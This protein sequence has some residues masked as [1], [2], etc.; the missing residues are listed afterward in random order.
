MLIKIEGIVS[1]IISDIIL[2]SNQFQYRD[3]D[4]FF[5]NSESRRLAIADAQFDQLRG[6]SN[7]N[8][9]GK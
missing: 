4:W 8:K 1:R 2:V 6:S 3:V 9:G 7:K 5:S